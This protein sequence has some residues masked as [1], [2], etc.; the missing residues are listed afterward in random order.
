MADFPALAPVA[1]R[2]SFG[3]LPVTIEPGGVRFLHDTQRSGCSLELQYQALTQAE[4]QLLRNHYRGQD[5]SHG[6][7][8]LSAE[9]WAGHTSMTDLV[10]AGTR[11]VYASV[12]EEQQL[13]GGLVD[14]SVAL[15]S[16]VDGA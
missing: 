8:E 16:V 10:P 14:I 1:R 11:W 13:R 6:S 7:F 4:A 2:Y 3:A 5:G 15:R 9:A 12:P